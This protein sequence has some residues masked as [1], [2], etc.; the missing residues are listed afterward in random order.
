MA[1]A[2]SWA[3][4]RT[5]SATS[6]SPAPSVCRFVEVIR[7]RGEEASDPATWD[8]AKTAKG[9]MVNSGPFDGTPAEEA[10]DSDHRLAVKSTASA[11]ARHLSAARLA[12]LAP[13]L[14]GR[15]DSDHLLPRAR[16][17]AGAGGSACRC[18]CPMRCS[19]SLPASR[20][21]AMSPSS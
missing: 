21:C 2:R 5:I 8:A 13:A 17:G 9:V 4:P 18:C 15:A 20:R 10:I 1:P 6:S 12:D 16:R 3:C 7:R 11:K 14:L 19:S